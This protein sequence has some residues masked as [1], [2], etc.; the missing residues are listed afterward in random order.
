MLD[1]LYTLFIAPIEF[2]MEK[3]LQWGFDHTQSWGWAIIVMS[4]VVNTVILPIYLKAEHWQEEERSIRKSFEEDEA[5][6]KR[7]FKGQERFAMI[8]TMH[9]QAGYSPLLTL[10]SSI[11]FFL[12]I[13]FFFAAYHFLSHFEP[14]QSISFLGLA[15]LSK[16]DELFSVGGFA[17]NVMPILMTIINIGSALI[18]TQNLSKRDQYQL[19][20]MAALFLVLLYNAASGLVLYWT[21]NNIYSLAKNAVMHETK[22]LSIKFSVPKISCNFKL[23]NSFSDKL[24][25]IKNW[26]LDSL[27]TLFWP[28]SL[29]LFCLIF[30]YFPIFLYISDPKAF[31]ISMDKVLPGLIGGCQLSIFALFVFWFCCR[32]KLRII[33]SFSVLVILISAIAFAFVFEPDIG[34][35]IEF[36]F[37]KPK[38]LR[39]KWNWLID[40]LVVLSSIVL[41]YGIAKFNFVSITKKFIWLSLASIFC[42]SIFSAYPHIEKQKTFDLMENYDHPLAQVTQMLS[43]SK[44]E[45]NIVVLMLDA[46]TG[47]HIKQIIGKDPSL[48]SELDGFT[49]Y[50]ETMTSGSGTIIGLPGILGGE[51]LAGHNLTKANRTETL[52]ETINKEWALFFN[53]LLLKNF[54]ISFMDRNWLKTEILKKYLKGNANLITTR[55]LWEGFSDVWMSRNNFELKTS[56]VSYFRFFYTYGLFKITPL[57]L[58]RR[59]YQGGKWQNSV[60]PQYNNQKTSLQHYAE[61]D[62]LSEYSRLVSSNKNQFKFIQN[63]TT[64]FP[65]SL[66]ENCRPIASRGTAEHDHRGINVPHLQTEYCAIKSVSNWLRWMKKNGIY[67]NTMVLVVSDHGYSDSEQI[68]NTWEKTP[69]NVVLHSLLLF[70]PFKSHGALKFSNDLTMNFDVQ[71]MLLKNLGENKPSPWKETQRIRKYTTVS[72]WQRTRHMPNYL[73]STDNYT[74]KGSI[75]KR[76]NWSKSFTKT[77]N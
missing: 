13:P 70:K 3:T 67:D 69:P 1:L 8:T 60:R 41:V 72:S 31:P 17:I 63:E 66:D 75:M 34:V 77:N 76:E 14:L 23:L 26:K 16:P 25:F 62:S 22:D 4:I 45:Q 28:A 73:I 29:L 33:L 50:T 74:I 59:L 54:E 10:R 49:W 24:F 42:F 21:F 15:D 35:M 2:W 5:M 47:G 43:F 38:A 57:S 11:G 37:Q 55:H 27:Q 12:Q 9:R 40:L 58:Q 44:T 71:N 19:Y 18:Y 61:L 6:I 30:I 64:H 56:A 20:G 65:W 68:F 7:T 52:E 39:F 36:V 46:F 53:Q 32:G 51:K 48:A